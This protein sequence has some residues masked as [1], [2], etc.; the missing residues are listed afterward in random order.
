MW[1][2]SR[3]RE[4]RKLH[5]ISLLLGASLLVG[6]A[7][8]QYCSPAVFR[9]PVAP[10]F[11]NA[12]VHALRCGVYRLRTPKTTLRLSTATNQKDRERGLMDVRVLPARAGMIF[13][14]PKGDAVRVFWM[15]NTLIPLDMVFVRADGTV[16]NIAENVPAT[17]PATPDMQI[18]RRY[19]FG[20]SV[21][22]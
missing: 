17:T 3:L 13:K 12:R 5:K 8:T 11:G 20:Q 21:M 19:G 14:F 10:P 22:W 4:L 1:R 15:K 16:N 7:N 2:V 9:S 6:A 18:P